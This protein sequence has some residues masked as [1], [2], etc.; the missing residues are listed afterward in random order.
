M[1]LTE[2]IAHD[3]LLQTFGDRPFRRAEALAVV[4]EDLLTALVAGGMIDLLEGRLKYAREFLELE[5]ELQAEAEAENESKRG[6][7]ASDAKAAWLERFPLLRH[8]REMLELC[9]GLV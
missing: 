3:K 5:K 6:A 1:T 4:G 2:A 8:G 7:L 9:G